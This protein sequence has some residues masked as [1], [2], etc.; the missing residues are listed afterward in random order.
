VLVAPK[1]RVQD[2]KKLVARLKSAG[3]SE[4]V[5]PASPATKGNR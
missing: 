1:S 2:V 5:S 4:H 3:R